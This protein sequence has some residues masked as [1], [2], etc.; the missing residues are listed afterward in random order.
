MDFCLQGAIVTIFQTV[1]RN[2]YEILIQKQMLTV[3]IRKND[4]K[5]LDKGISQLPF[6]LLFVIWV[7]LFNIN[8]HMSTDPFRVCITV[9]MI[10][11]VASRL[12]FRDLGM[13]GHAFSSR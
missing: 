9:S 6:K 8:L 13:G 10:M 3:L 12:R 2:I 1:E 11:S 4:H 5:G 7:N